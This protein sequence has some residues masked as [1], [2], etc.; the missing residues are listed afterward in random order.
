MSLLTCDRCDAT[1]DDA[2]D[3]HCL[4]EVGNMRRL[5]RE[6]V[7]CEPCRERAWDRQQG[8]WP[9]AAAGPHWTSNA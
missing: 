6:I 1:V 3:P 4:V 7:L 8:T 2:L 5:H 9:R